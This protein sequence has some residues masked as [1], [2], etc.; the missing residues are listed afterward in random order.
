[1]ENCAF[2]YQNRIL[3][4][5]LSAD[6]QAPLLPISNLRNQQGAASLGWRIPATSGGLTLTLNNA[7]PLRVASFHRTNMSATAQWKATV[8]N[9]GVA[10]WSASGSS[11]V[12]GQTLAI[13]PSAAVGDSVRIT[14]SDPD[15][16]DGWLDIPLAYIGPLWQPVR[17]F[18]TQSTRGNELGQDVTTAL[19]GA[20]FV[21]ARWYQRT[22][23]I[24]HQSLGDS[25]SAV[26]DEMLRVSATGQNIL[27]VPDPAAD[28]LSEKAL[29][30]R[31]QSS[32]ELSNPFG[33]ADRHSLTLKM[34]ERL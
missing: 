7:A 20:E 21:N 19:G 1:M 24:A 18:S 9:A 8:F 14:L 17:N 25:D 33:V 5:V 4:G 15:N 32:S 26:I 2:G 16:T 23:S 28:A 34:T 22:A 13:G 30:G 27:F 31:L 6:T 29:F 11:V 12:G 3:D 10:V